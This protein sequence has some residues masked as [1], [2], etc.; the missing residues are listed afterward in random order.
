MPV[1]RSLGRF[2]PSLTVKDR[3]CEC[4]VDARGLFRRARVT[5]P[6]VPTVKVLGAGRRWGALRTM[7]EDALEMDR[8]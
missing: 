4:H 8:D 7:S 3:A 6:I 2:T 5:T 1:R